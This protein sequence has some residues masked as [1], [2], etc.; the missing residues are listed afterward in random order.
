MSDTSIL[1]L[2][3]DDAERMRLEHL[4]H[5]AG[6]EVIGVAS[7]NEAS[8]RLLA[9]PLDLFICEFD[10]RDEERVSL[11]T[12]SK[13]RLPYLARLM[14]VDEANRRLAAKALDTGIVHFALVPPVSSTVLLDTVRALLRWTR[15]VSGST[16]PPQ[17][18]RNAEVRRHLR[19][20][21]DEDQAWE[22]ELEGQPS[23]DHTGDER[24]DSDDSPVTSTIRGRV[25]WY[26]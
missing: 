11:L 25:E 3:G 19:E 21:R 20:T 22:R 12:A 13:W 7:V 9:A 24:S 18:G 8:E 1:L 4:L 23:T 5:H 14:L 16:P 17:T 15:T 10:R 6:H 2:M 26:Y